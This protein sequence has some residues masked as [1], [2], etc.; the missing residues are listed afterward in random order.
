[1]KN[2]FCLLILLFIGLTATAQTFQKM[3]GTALVSECA[4]FTVLP[5]AAT[6]DFIVVAADKA[7]VEVTRWYFPANS[8]K[9]TRKNRAFS[10][11]FQSGMSTYEL[12]RP[13][14]V[15]K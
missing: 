11:R 12:S 14:K 4:T 13:V 5:D 10:Y 9:V 15:G 1:M 3:E 8:L 2:L 7:G 6:A